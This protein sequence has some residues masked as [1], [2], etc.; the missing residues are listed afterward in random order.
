MEKRL[1]RQGTD[2]NKIVMSKADLSHLNFNITRFDWKNATFEEF[3]ERLK[4][5]LKKV[6]G[7]AYGVITRSQFFSAVSIYNITHW[8]RDMMSNL[9]VDGELKLLLMSSLFA[10]QEQLLVN[11]LLDEGTNNLR[12][13]SIERIL[14]YQY[15]K[16]YDVENHA[17]SDE[18]SVL[19]A[20]NER[21]QLIINPVK[22]SRLND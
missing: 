7:N 3:C 9:V 11:L 17:L 19:T 22:N 6:R 16:I 8:R 5:Q 21:F 1:K 13:V 20:F 18:N 14:Q 12:R 10:D 4:T 2:S 15:N